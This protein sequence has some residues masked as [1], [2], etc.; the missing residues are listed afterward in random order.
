MTTSC[1]PRPPSNALSRPPASPEDILRRAT[2]AYRRFCETNGFIPQVPNQTLS[3]VQDGVVTLVNGRGLLATYR[4][5]ESGRLR[6]EHP[7]ALP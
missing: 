7:R 1:I 4:V 6:R 2:R 3:D 5:T